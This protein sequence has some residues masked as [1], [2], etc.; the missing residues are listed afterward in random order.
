MPTRRT[1]TLSA[2]TVMLAP[3]VQRM[4]CATAP[5]VVTVRSVERVVTGTQPEVFPR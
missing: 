1:V 5:G 2:L 3:F 4:S